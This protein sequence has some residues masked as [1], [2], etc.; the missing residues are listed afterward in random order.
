MFTNTKNKKNG[1]IYE[2][3]LSELKERAAKRGELIQFTVAQLRNKFKKCVSECKQAALTLKT[4]TGIKRFQEERGFG[5]WFSALFGLIKSRDSCKPEL[6][7]EPSSLD[8]QATE[9][10]THDIKV[11]TSFLSQ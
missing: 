1:E 5:K 11:K 7:L 10:T 6:A 3:I 4:A 9:V 2:K 8:Q